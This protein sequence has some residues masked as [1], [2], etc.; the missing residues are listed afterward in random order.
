MP[1]DILIPHCIVA[2]VPQEELVRV[3]RIKRVLWDIIL[4]SVQQIPTT[5]LKLHCGTM[6]DTSYANYKTPKKTGM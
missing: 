5:K 4:G 6:G 3:Y 1:Q 2:V